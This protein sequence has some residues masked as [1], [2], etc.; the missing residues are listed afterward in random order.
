[1]QQVAADTRS[2]VEVFMAPNHR[3]KTELTSG[4]T[5]GAAVNSSVAVCT[6]LNPLISSVSAAENTFRAHGG[7]SPI[8]TG[9]GRSG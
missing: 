2:L 5:C 6:C 4:A 3:F 7:A 9:R 8:Q 1:M